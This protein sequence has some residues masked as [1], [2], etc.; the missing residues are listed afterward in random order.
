L[1]LQELAGVANARN[2]G[3]GNTRRPAPAW[4][5]PIADGRISIETFPAQGGSQFGVTITDSGIGTTPEGLASAFS[6]FSQGDYGRH[7]SATYGGLGL[8]LAISKKLVEIHSGSI[9]GI[10]DGPG[11]GAS[12]TIE[13]PLAK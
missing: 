8:G 2:A 5:P 4:N 3:D 11:R 10:S 9:R 13:F 6:A 7:R 1:L 12:F